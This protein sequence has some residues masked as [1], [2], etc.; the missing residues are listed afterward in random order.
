MERMWEQ[1]E[2]EEEEERRRCLWG[3]FTAEVIT[4]ERKRERKRER[5]LQIHIKNHLSHKHLKSVK[6]GRKLEYQVTSQTSFAG[7]GGGG[8][9]S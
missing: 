2:E 8:A 4:R 6:D 5:D 9:P 7:V 3:S 1:E